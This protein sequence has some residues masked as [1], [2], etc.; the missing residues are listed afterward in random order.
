MYPNSSFPSG[1]V[2]LAVLP[3]PGERWTIMSPLAFAVVYY[4]AS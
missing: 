4:V 1:P 2:V 3:I